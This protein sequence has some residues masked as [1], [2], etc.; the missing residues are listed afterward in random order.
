MKGILFLLV[1]LVMFFEMGM[2]ENLSG[3]VVPIA[4]KQWKFRAAR[5]KI[6]REMASSVTFPFP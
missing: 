1:L 4:V 5:G 3:Q 2:A 6:V